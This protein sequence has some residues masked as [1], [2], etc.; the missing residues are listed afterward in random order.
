[1]NVCSENESILCNTAIVGSFADSVASAVV[2]EVE[3]TV[4]DWKVWVV[5]SWH[6]M[7]DYLEAQNKQERLHEQEIK[8]QVNLH[9][10]YLPL[11]IASHTVKK[12]PGRF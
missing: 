11:K 8:I 2:R 3:N 12:P 6:I 1:M 4:R 9:P 5:S 7:D 10:S